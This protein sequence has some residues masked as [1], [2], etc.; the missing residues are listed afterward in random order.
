LIALGVFTLEVELPGLALS[1]RLLTLD[2]LAHLQPIL[3]IFGG[4]TLAFSVLRIGNLLRRRQGLI[5]RTVQRRTGAVVIMSVFV[6]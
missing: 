4:I 5:W 6:R 1:L 2:L 3:H